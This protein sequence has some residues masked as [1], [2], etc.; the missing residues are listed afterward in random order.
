MKKN[1]LIAELVFALITK[2][3][4]QTVI[5]TGP[6][7]GNWTE[8]GSPYYVMGDIVVPSGITLIIDPGVIVKI[9]SELSFKVYGKILAEGNVNDSIVFVPNY[10]Y[11]K[12]LQI[13]SADTSIFEYC[14]FNGF[15]N[16]TSVNEGIKGGVL[17][18][19]DGNLIIN[20]CSF[21]SN[22]I[23]LNDDIYENKNGFGG[24]ICCINS[25]GQI[26][27]CQFIANQ[28]YNE[29]SLG[30]LKGCGGGIYCSGN[31]EVIG[32]LIANNYINVNS[33]TYLGSSNVE[34]YG[35]GIY[36][37]GGSL[38]RNR[39]L[40]NISYA[41]AESLFINW[42]PSVEAYSY[43]GGIYSE[44]CQILDNSIS[45]NLCKSYGESWYNYG[46]VESDAKGGGLYCNDFVINNL[47]FNNTCSAEGEGY[48]V[49]DYEKGGGVHGGNLYSNT[50]LENLCEIGSGVFSSVLKNCIVYNNIGEPG[51]YQVYGTAS[52]SCIEGGYPGL[53]NISDDPMFVSGPLGEY[54]LSQV[55]SGQSQ[56]SPC[57]DAGCPSSTLIIGTTRNDE[58]PDTGLVDM[59]FH[60]YCEPNL[61]AN[62]A[63]DTRFG[64]NPFEVP[65]KNKSYYF[66]CNPVLY[67]WDFENDGNIDSYEQDPTW[68]YPE[69]GIFSVK[70][71]VAAFGS[72]GMI[73]DTLFKGNYIHVCKFKSSFGS[74]ITSGCP[75][76]KV[77]FYDS[78][79]VV[80]T[81]IMQWYWDFDN[82]G[83]IDSYDQNPEW[84]Y[85][86]IGIYSV[87]LSIVDSSG[88]LTDT[89]LRDNFIE[90]KEVESAFKVN[91]IYGPAPFNVSFLDLS[92][93]QN[94]IIKWQW[95][96]QNDGIIDSYEQNPTFLY[97]EPGI[98][99]VK[100]IIQDTSMGYSD[101]TLNE[102][103]ITICKL[104]PG[105]YAEPLSGLIPLQVQFYDTTEF[106]YTQ[107]GSYFWDFDN[108]GIFDSQ[109]Q[110]PDWI[111]DHEGL[112]SA[113][114]II[115][116]TSETIIKS[117]TK[118]DYIEAYLSGIEL[119]NYKF[120]EKLKIFPNPFTSDIFVEFEF[121][122]PEF[123]TVQIFD[124]AFKPAAI[125]TKDEKVTIGKKSWK[126][127]SQDNNIPSGIYYIS[128]TT[129]SDKQLI[130]KCIKVE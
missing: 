80:N 60:Y 115:I 2:T 33:V 43:G 47:I 59:G 107:I 1:L 88:Y 46:E 74:D 52:F 41:S 38:E 26:K 15:I 30:Y 97:Y 128:L 105:F 20:N 7:G 108:D 54:Y 78:S 71:I 18:S 89:F 3:L 45:L 65:F 98:Y 57:V 42:E 29:P 121:D 124:V 23:Y 50:I 39:V 96:F 111:Y 11:W 106:E 76:L 51:T 4:S 21:V 83:T 64:T 113:R 48:S 22:K 68:T 69:I 31:F 34:A 84:I 73:L 81:D 93:S 120:S 17:C 101:T 58:F 14:S 85:N 70:L 90:V 116:D 35:G 82:D 122:K 118:E 92:C 129:S 77:Y 114:L 87:K 62:F 5:N 119:N 123:V 127:K 19:Q 86:Q 32:N 94:S 13:Y 25:S 130:K 126:L 99:S 63:V 24:A 16:K 100:L 79:Q 36:I 27:N 28:I 95:D 110:N 12:G 8:D 66:Q 125:I 40:Q 67:A 72:N 49:W 102:E 37:I 109:I 112:Y 75:P 10:M 91:N 6:V 103:L 61:F 44:Y 53:G 117:L 56:Q 55:A 104:L 9:F